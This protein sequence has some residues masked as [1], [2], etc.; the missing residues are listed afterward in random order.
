VSKHQRRKSSA[1]ILLRGITWPH[2]GQRS[3]T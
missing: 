1:V 2:V 3:L